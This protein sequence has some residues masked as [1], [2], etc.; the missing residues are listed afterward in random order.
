MPPDTLGVPVFNCG[1]EPTP[2]VVDSEDLGAVSAPHVVRYHG[3]DLA[4]V[5]LLLS[6]NY[7][8]RRKQVLLPH[9]TKNTLT[10][11]FKTIDEA[12]SCPDLAVTL[13]SEQRSGDVFTDES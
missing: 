1:E 7:P 12:N 11:D 3:D 13:T 8:V 5:F 2:T 9:D 6:L 10:A 4:F